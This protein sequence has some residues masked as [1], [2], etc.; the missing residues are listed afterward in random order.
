MLLSILIC[1]IPSRKE[2]LDMLIDNLTYQRGNLPFTYQGCEVNEV[3]IS[4]DN[5]HGIST[6]AKRN[7]LLKGAHGKFI[8]FIDDD[9][10]IS[11]EYLIQII[12]TIKANPDVDC[13]GMKG[14]I[15]TN[16]T[17]K[18]DW[19]ISKDFG[20][21]YEKDNIYYRTPNHISPVRREIALKVG[22]PDKNF[23]EDADYS[24]GILPYLKSEAKID[25]Q[26]YFYLYRTKEPGEIPNQ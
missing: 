19:E 12:K 17:D 18:K 4:V 13:I 21:W 15:T 23:G 14:W 7:K 1:T 6:G 2:M 22:F 20:S 8:V 9:D 10:R 3:Q 5:T 11:D 16:G 25:V 26:I 24:M